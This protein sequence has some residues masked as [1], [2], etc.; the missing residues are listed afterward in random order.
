MLQG[1]MVVDHG[2]SLST[3]RIVAIVAIK[4]TGRMIMK[5]RFC[6]LQLSVFRHKAA[7]LGFLAPLLIMMCA[8]GRSSDQ[9]GYDALKLVA[10]AIRRAG[11]VDRKA[12]RDQ[13]V[14]TRGYEGATRIHSYDEDRHPIKSAVIMRIQDAQI[15]FYQ[16][17][18]L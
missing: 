2:S 10:T 13:L 6:S 8:I 18:E 3:V 11:S 4:A 5:K 14:D 7:R 1:E 16:Q 12:I 15:K 17:V 9:S